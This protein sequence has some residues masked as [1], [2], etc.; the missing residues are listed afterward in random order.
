MML[1]FLPGENE[2]THTAP[3]TPK[4]VFK[5]ACVVGK[6]KCIPESAEC[7][8]LSLN[9]RHSCFSSNIFVGILKSFETVSVFTLPS[10]EASQ[11]GK[12]DLVVG[13]SSTV[14]FL[15][16]ISSFLPS[17]DNNQASNTLCARWSTRGLFFFNFFKIN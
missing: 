16:L 6:K 4:T 9:K 8:L 11:K 15:V 5:M 1:N 14:P 17:M 2:S 13:C 12:A 10:A 3:S 7:Y